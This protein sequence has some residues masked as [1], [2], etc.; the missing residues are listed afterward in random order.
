MAQRD[1]P[2]SIGD[3]YHCFNVAIEKRSAFTD[4][5][6]YQRFLELLYLANDAKP[7]RRNDFGNLTFERVLRIPRGGQLV[8]VGAFCLMPSHFHLVLRESAPG[9]ISAFMR[10]IGTA[11]T[12]YFNSRYE[13]AGNLFLKPFRSR[14]VPEAEF[15]HL[16][17][18]VHCS[19]ASLYE[20]EWK[21]R[22]I[23]DPQFLGE[24]IAAYPYSSF[25]AYAG[26]STP[27]DAIL[28]AKMLSRGRAVPMQRTL[29][30]AL[31]YHVDTGISRFLINSLDA[32]C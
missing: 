17:S 1:V 24:R 13:R 6:D 9:G 18:Y 31:T 22:H 14:H 25:R 29:K 5:A 19:P 2:F 16:V 27:S 30:E 26:I 20:P 8:S 32:L 23:V 7:L 10:K 3:W 4:A 28:D 21:T 11:Y 15:Q 12:M